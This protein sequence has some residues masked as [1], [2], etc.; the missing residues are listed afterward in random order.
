M[1]GLN[2]ALPE[3]TFPDEFEGVMSR[4]VRVPEKELD[5]EVAKYSAMRWR[6]RDT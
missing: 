1:A 6:L 2:K 4:L 5:V 3:T